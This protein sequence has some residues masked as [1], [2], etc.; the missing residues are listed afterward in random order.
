MPLEILDSAFVLLRG[1]ASRKRAEITPPAGLRILLARIE[2]V[3]A[4]RELANHER[5][6][7]MV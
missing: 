1:S 6:L 7:P 2:P 4:G 3:L 5:R